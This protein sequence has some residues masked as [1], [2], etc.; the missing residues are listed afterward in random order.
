MPLLNAIT[1][2]PTGFTAHGGE[3]PTALKYPGTL[4]DVEIMIDKHEHELVK[5]Q[6]M[7][8][9][10]NSYGFRLFA[11][12]QAIA[13]ER[14]MEDITIRDSLRLKNNEWIPADLRNFIFDYWDEL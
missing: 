5:Y 1:L 8:F 4:E 6:L 13:Q 7:R 3:G 11:A 14:D 9:M 12:K 2:S 10:F